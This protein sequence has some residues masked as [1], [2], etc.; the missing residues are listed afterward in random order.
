[1]EFIVWKFSIA[2]SFIIASRT[3]YQFFTSNK[4]SIIIN[5]I[6][7]R[8]KN[9]GFFPWLEINDFKY[10]IEYGTDDP[11]ESH[12]LVLKY[13]KV[14]YRICI[15]EMNHPKESIESIVEYYWRKTNANTI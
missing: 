6:G 7:I 5:N 2:L 14:W 11:G 3:I 12:Y 10:E 15:D 9:K 13:E 8:F 1:M 4:P